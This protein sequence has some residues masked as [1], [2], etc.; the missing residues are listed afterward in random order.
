MVVDPLRQATSVE[1]SPGQQVPFWRS[2]SE[3]SRFV[4][5]GFTRW[6]LLPA[7]GVVIVAIAVALG[8]WDLVDLDQPFD[9][10]LAGLWL[11]MTLALSWRFRL[12][13]DI[14]L[15]VVGACGGF[16]IEWWGTTTELWTYFTNERPPLWIIPA[17]PVAALATERLAYVMH[18]AF[19]A[20]M[21]W[22]WRAAWLGLPVFIGFMLRFMTPSWHITS[23]H[24]VLGIMLG[25]T[26]STRTARRDVTL[27][28]MGTA[29]G[30]FLEY[31]GTTRECWTYYTHETPPWV[32]AFAHGFASVAFFRAAR[33]VHDVTTMIGVRRA[34]AQATGPGGSE[35]A[36]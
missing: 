20:G 34:A 23:S 31:W 35:S 1:E 10:L 6:S 2:R 24:V 25:V 36:I 13:R 32:T 27:F 21:T 4:K 29:L 8:W 30:W 9:A 28:V 26:I 3:L 14:V 11:F 5:S 17:W 7:L 19:P 33:V 15:V 18:R 16:L 22:L 12:R